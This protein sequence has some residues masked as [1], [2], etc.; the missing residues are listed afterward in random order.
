VNPTYNNEFRCRIFNTLRDHDEWLEGRHY[1]P[2]KGIRGIQQQSLLTGTLVIVL[3]HSEESEF[4]SLV[5]AN[6]VIGWV[7]D[8]VLVGNRKARKAFF[9]Q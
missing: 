2:K 9:K 5:L 8:D 1:P 6:G 4:L 7:Y 3:G